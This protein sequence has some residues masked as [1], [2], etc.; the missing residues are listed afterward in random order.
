VQHVAL[1]GAAEVVAALCQLPRQR[2]DEVLAQTQAMAA[3]GLRVLGVARANWSGTAWPDKPDAPGGF[4][5]EFLGLVAFADPLRPE[6]PA[7][8]A[9]CHAAGL[10]VLM[11][12]GDHPVT[13]LA[14]AAKA[15]LQSQGLTS[16]DTQA[17]PVVT[18]AEM[19]AMS[20]SALQ[21]SLRDH[22]VFARVRPQQKLRIV[23]A[24]KAN[25]QVVAMTGDGVND[26]PSL[27]AAHVGIAMGGRGTDVAR[28]ASSLVLLDD[29]FGAIVAA[30]RL[31][32]RIFDNL[33][34]A[35][36]FVLAVHVPI[37]G[38]SLLPVLM[39][40]PLILAPVHIAFLEL[41]ISPVCSVVFEAE[42]EE[43]D[44]MQRPPRDPAAALFSTSLMAWSFG[45]G[46][47]VLLAVAAFYTVLQGSELAA[48]TCRALT[49]VAL[50]SCNVALILA[51][52]TR[53]GGMVAGWTSP[54]PM[55]WRMLL[56]TFGLLAAALWVAPLREV[57]RFGPAPLPWMAVAL[58]IGVPVLLAL[59]ALKRLQRS[60]SH[61]G[62]VA[63]APA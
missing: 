7:A 42:A 54:N 18:G 3:G 50:I 28:E 13:A 39:G 26:A 49:F 44:V 47:L 22:N 2:A 37:A 15:G 5:F 32:R 53:H 24:L 29:N 31:G 56:A 36:A 52:R 23:E 16:G 25:G 57:F 21:A 4:A 1:K 17:L 33:R 30:V 61:T 63:H 10:R 46:F 35:L 34:K 27:K 19:D 55:L 51:N 43:A 59:E 9:E 12:T 58:A 8:I 60:R 41:L 6:V 38:L 14:I 48:N 62:K 45:Q 11:I 20:D 40:W